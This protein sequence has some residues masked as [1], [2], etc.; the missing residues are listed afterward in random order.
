MVRR[1]DEDA[2]RIRIRP[3]RGSRPRTKR[4][5]AHHDAVRGLVTAVDYAEPAAD[6]LPV[7]TGR[8]WKVGT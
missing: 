7:K 8:R 6:L 4:R 1:L 2:V 3:G 5:P